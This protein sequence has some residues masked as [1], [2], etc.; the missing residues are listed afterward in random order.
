VLGLS[1]D[2]TARKQAE[3]ALRKSESELARAQ[4]L[5]ALGRLAGGIAHDFNNNLT[6]ILGYIDMMAEDIGE[7]SPMKADLEEMRRSAERASALARR[8]LAFGR[9]QVFQP[10]TLDLNDVVS[11]LTP[12]VKRLLGERIRLEVFPAPDLFCVTADP[13]ESSNR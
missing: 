8:L 11:G 4:K 10:R 7:H 3:D 2:M 9:R 5:E 13:P 12:V 6:A 1:R